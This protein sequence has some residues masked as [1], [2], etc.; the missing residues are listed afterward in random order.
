MVEAP[1]LKSFTSTVGRQDFPGASDS[2]GNCGSAHRGDGD[3]SELSRCRVTL[4]VVRPWIAVVLAGCRFGFEPLAGLSGTAR[5]I[6]VTIEGAGAV[7]SDPPGLACVDAC[8][9]TFDGPVTLTATPAGP[10]D[11]SAWSGAPC[12][13]TSCTVDGDQDQNVVVEFNAPP[14]INTNIVFATAMEHTGALKTVADTDGLAAGDRLCNEVAAAAGH[15]GTFVAF[16]SSATL[17]VDAITRLGTARGWVR[18]DGAV[19][20]PDETSI[21]TYQQIYPIDRDE[22]DRGL[23]AATDA[24][25]LGGSENGVQSSVND[26]AGFTDGT[27]S[28]GQTMPADTVGGQGITNSRP[29]DRPTSLICMQTDFA[30]VP[31]LPPPFPIGRRA[32]VTD[33]LWSGA[34]GLAGADASCQADADDA[35]LAGTFVAGLATSTQSVADRAGGL[36]GPWRRPDGRVVTLGSLAGEVFDA[37]LNRNAH[38]ESQSNPVFVGAP[39][40]TSLATLNC[41]DW[42]DVSGTAQTIIGDPTDT[43][44]F[45]QSVPVTCVV[46]HLVCLERAP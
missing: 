31:D 6:S 15:T 46:R 42:T 26:C 34:G 24:L 38:G 1:V 10:R 25:W 13:G 28:M 29:C 17:G 41:A 35:G 33:E 43:R 4:P 27:T 9:A 7:V 45:E 32:F 22:L 39:S 16:L 21:A 23:T 14:T 3:F 2:S 40:L 8:T 36:S 37:P 18:T 30:V 20:F 19:V 5:S 12:T 44:S 11:V